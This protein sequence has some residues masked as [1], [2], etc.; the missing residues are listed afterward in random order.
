MILSSNEIEVR[1]LVQNR[2]S[3]G[4]RDTT[5]D[6]TVGEIIHEGKTHDGPSYVLPT[7][8]MVWVVSN[9]KFVLPNDITGLAT[10]RTTW[11][12]NGILALNVG[13]V[14]PGWNGHLATALVNFSN[15]N[16]E[17]ERGEAFLRVLFISHTKT[18]A[19]N[20]II[21]RKAYLDQIRD[22]S[23][24]IPSTFLDLKSLADEVLSRLYGSSVFANWLTRFGL[25]IALVAI[26]A[27]FIPIAY[28]VSSEF[29]S[30]KADVQKMQ[31]DIAKIINRQNEMQNQQHDLELKIDK[32]TH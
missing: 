29:M 26:I 2:S 11:T 7:R 27:T 10:L 17:I 5:Y 19:K 15:T 22:K 30:R 24:K 25:I 14:D 4:I 18:N 23:S 3:K 31:D 16:F 20:I 1:G 28:G 12:H 32:N 9:E 21:D 8:G 13:I 6:A